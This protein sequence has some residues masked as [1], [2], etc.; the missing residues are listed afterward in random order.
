MFSTKAKL[1]NFRSGLA[2]IVQELLTMGM[3]DKRPAKLASMVTFG[4]LCLACAGGCKLPSSTADI[5][6]WHPP[7]A[8]SAVG[9]R[10]RLEPIIGPPELAGAIRQAMLDAPPSDIGRQITVIDGN[11]SPDSNIALVSA[12]DRPI[13]KTTNKLAT[14]KPAA[15]YILRG[16]V[17]PPPT[18]PVDRSGTEPP[19]QPIRM[20]WRLLKTGPDGQTAVQSI[21]GTAMKVEP[22][23]ILAP[24]DSKLIPIENSRRDRLIRLAANQSFDLIA[25]SIRRQNV[26]LVNARSW[27]QGDAIDR[28]NQSAMH[29][30]W[31]T[32]TQIYRDV[33]AAKPRSH[34]AA[35]NLALAQVAAQDFDAARQSIALAMSIKPNEQTA[36]TMAWIETTYRNHQSAFQLPAKNPSP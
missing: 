33:L 14:N 2:P 25:P 36:A 28:A 12:T 16:E 30:D 34:A 31:L 10:V 23:P 21:G 17:L 1:G 32:A 24:E 27:Q 7:I 13:P 29:G 19:L 4:A 15:D 35:H 20:T 26:T 5:S 3:V 6:V 18:Q 11:Q 9:Q 22:E 8:Q